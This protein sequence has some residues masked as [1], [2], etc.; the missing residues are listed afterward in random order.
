MTKIFVC[1]KNLDKGISDH[2]KKVVEDFLARAKAR[3]NAEQ[4]ATIFQDGKPATPE[5]LKMAKKIAA[6]AV[7]DEDGR[8]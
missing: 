3:D 1:G 7:E 6:T 4:P 2:D 8:Q 5:R